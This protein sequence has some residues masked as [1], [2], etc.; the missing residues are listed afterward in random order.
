MKD[1]NFGKDCKNKTKEIIRKLRPLPPIDLEN[2]IL[3][4]Q[5][6]DVSQDAYG[7]ILEIDEDIIVKFDEDFRNY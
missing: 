6:I 4:E 3:M 7:N 1:K 5:N 2:I